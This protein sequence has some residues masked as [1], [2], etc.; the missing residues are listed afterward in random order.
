MCGSFLFAPISSRTYQGSKQNFHYK[1][2]MRPY[3]SI[4]Q[5]QM[6]HKNTYNPHIKL[7][8]TSINI[9]EVSNE[10]IYELYS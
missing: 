10:V 5:K 6:L 3:K 9:H 8:Q 1:V 4:N 2:C 7:Y